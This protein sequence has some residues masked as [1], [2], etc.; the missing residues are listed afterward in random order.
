MIITTEKGGKF[1]KGGKALLPTVYGFEEIGEKVL[2]CRADMRFD[3]L[4]G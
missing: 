1:T 3:I 2:F 4:S